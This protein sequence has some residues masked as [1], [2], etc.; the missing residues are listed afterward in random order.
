MNRKRFTG[1]AAVLLALSG[2]LAQGKELFHFQF[3]DAN[4]KRT[5]TSGEFRL[6]SKRVPLLVQRKA[7]R[8]AAT[9]M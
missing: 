9:R 6:E 8:L 5:L 2:C 3:P 4:G 1:M 7:L